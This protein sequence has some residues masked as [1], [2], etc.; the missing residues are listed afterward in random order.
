M[1][2]E[3]PALSNESPALSNAA[4]PVL[5][6]ALG[7]VPESFRR[8]L[9]E[10]LPPQLPPDWEVRDIGDTTDAVI[11]A[12]RAAGPNLDWTTLLVTPHLGG[13]Y[14]LDWTLAG[15]LRAVPELRLALFARGGAE[16]TSL[17]QKLAAHG[18]TNILLDQPPPSVSDIVRLVTTTSGRDTLTPFLS[19]TPPETVAAPD[20]LEPNGPPSPAHRPLVVTRHTHS[21]REVPLR[22]RVVAVVG[23][24]GS[25]GK[26]S[27]CANL[28]TAAAQSG[29]T[30][31]ALD[32]D[33]AKPALALRF[34]PTSAPLPADPRS[35]LTTINANHL[36]DR[37]LPTDPF[38]L[39]AA[40]RE[41]IRH[42]VS[43]CLAAA[44][45]AGP[46]L[47]PGPSRDSDLTAEPP[48]GLLR[49]LI[50][51]AAAQSAVVFVDTGLPSDPEWAPIVAQAD[52]ILLV[53]APEYEHVLEAV[54]VLHRLDHLAI[55]R[56]KTG[57]LVNR[58]AR[59]GISTE[60]IMN[61]HLK[62]PDRPRLPLWGQIPWDPQAWEHSVSQ[63]RPLALTRPV[64]W[65]RLLFATT[66]LKTAERPSRWPSFGLRRGAAPPAV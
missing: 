15:C 29:Y 34:Q 59:W 65:R 27:L 23:G 45:P 9:F 16:T 55:D 1:S 4:H 6:I 36:T 32:L 56:R 13:S 3:S 53:V 48:D 33:W 38:T 26:T 42:F 64:P 39:S 2:N 62:F 57:V 31:V 47:I 14:P 7:I 54:D 61:T 51:L 52:R 58:R 41:D 60:D 10:L 44:T 8:G 40:D 25:V 37:R 18:L 30:A 22:T 5:A 49:V 63:H 11:A 35:L 17:V 19:E 21:V 28:A 24:K 20:L 12:V 46:V 50:E 66:G 43:T